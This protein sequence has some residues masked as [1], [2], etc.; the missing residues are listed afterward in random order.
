MMLGRVVGEVWATRKNP[1][2]EG[3]KALLV[4]V[5]GQDGEKR[6]PTG[7]V[8]VAF[9]SI[10]A[11]I[12]HTVAVAWGSGARAVFAAPDNRWT[13]VDAAVARIVDAVLVEKDG[14]EV[15]ERED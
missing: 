11:R 13:L 6:T 1:R 3:R 9:D 10:G 12:G 15:E 8:V 2:I 7:E 14:K 5:L 4:A